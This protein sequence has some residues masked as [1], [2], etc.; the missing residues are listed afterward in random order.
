MTTES[1]WPEVDATL[2]QLPEIIL[3][4]QAFKLRD[5]TKGL[6]EGDVS[7][8]ETSRN[9][10]VVFNIIAPALDGYKFELLRVNYETKRPYPAHVNCSF[11]GEVYAG[12]KLQ[13][14]I[15][16][17]DEDVERISVSADTQEEFESLLRLVFGSKEVKGVLQSLLARI[18]YEN[19]KRTVPESSSSPAKAG[20]SA[21]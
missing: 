1:F 15:P 3:V 13:G 20:D 5:N 19:F 16:H 14:L 2:I 8:T 11:T 18:N 21:E 6:L 12:I 7:I 4:T 17:T 10:M 9:K